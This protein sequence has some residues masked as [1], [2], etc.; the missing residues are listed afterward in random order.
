VVAVGIKAQV[1]NDNPS[2]FNH[3]YASVN[4][5]R[6]HYVDEGKGPLVLLL[7]GFPYLWYMWRH[8]IRVLANAGYRVVAPDLR[9]FGQSES[10]IAVEAYDLTQ[11]VGDVV[12]LMRTLGETNGVVIG[13]D[14]GAWIA[15]AAAMMRPDLFRG[16]VMFNTPV[17]ARG[18]VKPSVGWEALKAQGRTFHHAYFQQPEKPDREMALDTRKTLRSIYYSISGSAKG[19]DRWRILFGFDESLLDSFTD[20]NELPAWLSERALDHYVAEYERTGFTGAINYYRCRDR[21]WEITSFL[22]GAV[23]HVPS[24]FIGGEA[25]AAMDLSSDAYDGLESHIL[26]LRRKML[27]PGVGHSVPEEAPQKTQKLLLE[28]LSLLG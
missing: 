10:P 9:G 4:G 23:I 12:G 2:G 26:D 16:L 25:D 27:L 15:H 20:P 1:D 22:E 5:I 7:H 19:T 11:A 13:H 6:M 18:P 8:Q 24:M 14:L 28:F 3:R 21:N 17:P